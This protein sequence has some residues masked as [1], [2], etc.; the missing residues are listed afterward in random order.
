MGVL[1]LQPNL[2]IHTG[3]FT[4]TP[5]MR[6]RIEEVLD[7]ERI[8]YGEMS[9]A[10]EKRFA[11]MHDS[12]YVV[13]SNSGT[14][15]LH[16]ALQALKELHGWADGDEVLVPATTF[17]ATANVVLHNRLTPVLVDVE[18]DTFGMDAK[19]AAEK[20]TTS[21]RAIIPVHLFGQPCRDMTELLWLA[22]QCNYRIIEDSCESMFV[23]HHG[24]AV[25]SMGDIECFSFYMAH[26]IPAGVGG[27]ATTNNPD[28]AAKMR[29]LVNHGLSIDN[30]NPDRNYAPRPM[31]N[32]R[33]QFD[34]IGHSF[35]IT[36][37]EAALA[38]AQLDDVR[39]MLMR[40]ARNATHL[41]AGIGII[42][43]SKG[44]PLALTRTMPG[45]GH[46]WMMFPMVLRNEPKEALC[47]WLNE[48]Q[49]ET[50]DIPS[51]LH[52]P[53]Y[54]WDA[55]QYPVSDWIARSGLYVASHQGLSPDDCQYMVDCI[56][57]Y[58]SQSVQVREPLGDI[59]DKVV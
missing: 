15:S 8:G 52:Q 53:C 34:A 19:D 13:L 22:K 21:T 38:L 18:R 41:E 29:S 11:A 2:P 32:R 59:Y 23:D 44:D 1:P 33:F 5:I 3:T 47:A 55:S 17:V 6:Q 12:R 10:L 42:N 39:S 57:N 4:V 37:F 35:R 31:L 30:L 24:K 27:I 54:S 14:S 49:I 26:L 46:S 28:Y 7:S 20:I 58:F 50:R 25:G 43:R 40:R 48:R 9:Q 36:E 51:L 56:S 45:S 16:V